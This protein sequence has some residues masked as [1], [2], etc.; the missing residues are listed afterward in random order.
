VVAVD[1]VDAPP[2]INASVICEVLC[3]QKV[4]NRV[5]LR[6]TKLSK[7]RLTSCFISFRQNIFH[8]TWNNTSLA[9]WFTLQCERFAA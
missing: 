6:P 3:R 9:T 8:S 4:H 7:F 2:Q 1:H 5:I